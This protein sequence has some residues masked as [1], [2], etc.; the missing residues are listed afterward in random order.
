M[1]GIIGLLPCRQMAS[2]IPAIILSNARQ[3]VV[4][5]NVA[6]RARSGHVSV[7]QKETRGVVIEAAGARPCIE[8]KVARVALGRIEH[9]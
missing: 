1:Y 7:P 2:G 6:G 9:A 3:V 8:R 4:V 5:A